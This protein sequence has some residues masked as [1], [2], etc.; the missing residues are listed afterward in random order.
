M[1]KTHLPLKSVW[2]ELL[3]K[4][5]SGHPNLWKASNY[6][7]HQIWP[8]RLSLRTIDYT[9]NKYKKYFYIFRINQITFNYGERKKDQP[10]FYGISSQNLL[11]SADFC[12]FH[13]HIENEAT[14][15]QCNRS[16]H[17]AWIVGIQASGISI[18]L[19]LLML[20]GWNL[21]WIASLTLRV[22]QWGSRSINLTLL[23]IGICPVSLACSETAE[24]WVRA[25][26]VSHVLL[27]FLALISLFHR[28]TLCCIH[29]G[30]CKRQVRP[31]RCF[32]LENDMPWC[33]R[34][35][36]R[37]SDTP[38]YVKENGSW[39]KFLHGFFV[40]CYSRFLCEF[41]WKRR[42]ITFRNKYWWQMFLFL[43]DN[44]RFRCEEVGSFV[45]ALNNTT[46]HWVRMAWII[47]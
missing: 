4:D 43:R 11:I 15:M 3:K 7:L 13:R 23:Q 39:F 28:Y 29:T 16:A 12:R 42:R 41:S 40:G 46:L 35:R 38:F 18:P 26:C 34:Q 30:S 2:S 33:C 17:T 27:S 10:D 19:S 31:K 21:I 22:Y 14:T 32:K 47:G 5:Q 8:S 1:W 20:Q 25:N 24:V 45:Q 36:W 44:W 6:G 9:T 37:V